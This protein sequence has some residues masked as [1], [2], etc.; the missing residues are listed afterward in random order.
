MPPRTVNNYMHWGLARVWSEEE[1]GPGLLRPLEGTL[2]G[3]ESHTSLGRSY[4][5]NK[6]PN[7]VWE[8]GRAGTQP[9]QH[10]RCGSPPPGP[11]PRPRSASGGGVDLER[12]YKCFRPQLYLPMWLVIRQD[13]VT[14][15]RSAQDRSVYPGTHA[16]ALP[17]HSAVRG[18]AGSP[19]PEGQTPH[20][21]LAPVPYEHRQIWW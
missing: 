2:G 14:P 8:M 17:S 15:N 7:V 18:S 21:S 10:S 19:V 9:A 13:C 1:G 12:E 11:S 16:H 5:N 20:G 6:K 4:A 3:R